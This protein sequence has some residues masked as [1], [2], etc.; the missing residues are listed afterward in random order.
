MTLRVACLMYIPPQHR[1]SNTNRDSPSAL[2]YN[3]IA[4]L[5]KTLTILSLIGLLTSLG[6]WGVSY[7]NLF[8]LGT[9]HNL[10]TW[11]GYVLYDYRSTSGSIPP[12]EI[13]WR[14][15]CAPSRC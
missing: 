15:T 6:L 11:D 9:Q 3:V 7:L 2:A 8:Y 12:A 5:R 13:G 10:N 1:P 4:M 14:A